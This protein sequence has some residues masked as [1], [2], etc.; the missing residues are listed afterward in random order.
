MYLNRYSVSKA[1]QCIG[2]DTDVGH[3]MDRWDMNVAVYRKGYSG[4]EE[5]LVGH[6]RDRYY[7]YSVSVLPI[8]LNLGVGTVF[9][10]RSHLTTL[11][12]SSKSIFF[13][14][15]HAVCYPTHLDG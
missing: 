15:L 5:P 1:I 3:E 6:L 7:Q 11:A 12:R 9:A 4:R 10:Y 8:G 14:T 13:V 2:I